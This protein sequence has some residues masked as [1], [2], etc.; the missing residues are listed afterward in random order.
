MPSNTSV[1]RLRSTTFKPLTSSSSNPGLRM[2]ARNLVATPMTVDMDLASPREPS[3][4]TVVSSQ[5]LERQIRL[6]LLQSIFAASARKQANLNLCYRTNLN[7]KVTEQVVE[8][9][10]L[11]LFTNKSVS[12]KT[13]RVTIC[14]IVYK[15]Y[16]VISFIIFDNSSVT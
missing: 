16:S 11:M 13:E 6:L 7:L 12:R 14:H 9:F 5:S 8:H 10:F 1:R 15:Q 2:S 4:R 3:R